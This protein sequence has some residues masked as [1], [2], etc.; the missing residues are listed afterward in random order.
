M[1][2]I[3]NIATVLLF[4]ATKLAELQKCFGYASTTRGGRSAICDV[5]ASVGI[6][7]AK[8]ILKPRLHEQILSGNFCVTNIIDRVDR[9]TNNC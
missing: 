1:C 9:A 2:K 6:R 3:M 8:P 5:I 7:N 4:I